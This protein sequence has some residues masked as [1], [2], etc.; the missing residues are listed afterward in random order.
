[1]FKYWLWNNFIF[2]V[3]KD[4]R[5]FKKSLNILHTFTEKVN[6]IL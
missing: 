3:S 5:E 1:M 4:G 6:T 2:N